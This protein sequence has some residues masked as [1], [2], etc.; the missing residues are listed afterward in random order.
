MIIW[1]WGKV[2]K[3][4]IGVV[5]NNTCNYCNTT[6]GWK[7]CLIRTWFTLFFIPIIPYKKV[8]AICCPNC[9]SYINLTEDQFLKLKYDIQNAR[10]GS[11]SQN[12]NQNTHII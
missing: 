9:G 2:T 7:L 5:F 6:S 4:V 10:L 11:I 3:K 1:G 12:E 8:Y